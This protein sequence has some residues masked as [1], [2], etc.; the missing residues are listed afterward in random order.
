MTLPTIGVRF[1]G[2]LPAK[3][4]IELAGIAER[5]SFGSLWFTENIFNRGILPAVVGSIIATRTIKV[6]LGVINPY[7]RHPTQI[8]MDVGALDELSAGRLSVGIGSGN[9]DRIRR[10]GLDYDKPL[11]AVRDAITIV[12]GM[13]RGER[14]TYS[15]SVFSVKDVQL[16]Y[17]PPRPALPLY[18]AA[19]GDQAMRV[20]GQVADGVVISNMCP[21]GFTTRA[22]RLL[23]EGA[24]EVGQDAPQAVVQFVFC[25]ARKQR[26][27]ARAMVRSAIAERLTAYW[28]LGESVPAVRQAM[29]RES[30]IAE[31]DFASAVGRLN[32][33]VHP[34]L[35]IDDRFVDAYSI[36][37]NAD[38]CLT[39]ATRFANAGVTDLVLTL[40]GEQSAEDM[41]Y[42]GS[43]LKG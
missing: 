9:G 26:S 3:D 41:I 25:A 17:T 38:D 39:G 1:H 7:S 14:L 32:A 37:G 18:M 40:V 5:H 31:S 24:R 13:I 10:M 21:P 29:Y 15:G 2:G 4:C 23:T 43:A 19:M 20:C 22:L 11:A 33:G 27:E 28:T 42:L 8:A 36:A 12:R 34:S 6:G 35:A 30:G 16:E